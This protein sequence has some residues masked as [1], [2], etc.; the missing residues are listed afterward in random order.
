MTY[1][2]NVELANRYSVSESTVRN[3]V[4]MTN[5]GKL[6]LT[7]VH[8]EGH[9]YVAKST[10][11]IPIIK[12]LVGENRKYRNTRSTKTITPRPEFYKIFTETQIYDIIRSL[13]LHHEIPRQYN[14]F[15]KGADMWDEYTQQL[16][17]QSQPNL[18][19][20]TIKILGENQ[21]YLDR[22]LAKYRH[23]NVV[24]IGVGNVLPAKG[25]LTHLHRQGTLI[26]YNAV[27]VS[28]RMLEIAERN[29]KEWF[30]D[31]IPFTGYQRDIQF[32]RFAEIVA[33]SYLRGKTEDSINLFLLLGATPCNFKEPDDAFRVIRESMNP[34]DLILYTDK[35][36]KRD[37]KPE[38]FNFDY[39]AEQKELVLTPRHRLVFELLNIHDSFY[40]VEVSLDQKEQ[41]RYVRARL[42]VA[43]S[44]KL[45]HNGI[46]RLLEFEKG[47]TI[48]LWRSWQ[49]TAK[50]IVD[51]FDRTGFYVLHSSQTEDHE[52]ILTIADVK[53]G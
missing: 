26:G 8:H 44:L 2:K 17:K 16:L 21:E 43:L 39:E 11:N 45:S 37:M 15:S 4:K 25:L 32:E 24:D 22:R 14:Y 5:E 7:L 13:E 53:R 47:D 35:L 42:K 31:K 38:W 33:N 12:R 30:G 29:I 19:T 1:F 34:N 23:V 3:W 41:Y 9:S 51:Q 52:Y 6:E 28:P 50:D 20:G 27:D 46:G 49:V 10:S 18:L 40:D 48:Q 36:E